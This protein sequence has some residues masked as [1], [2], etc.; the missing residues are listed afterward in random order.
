MLPAEAPPAPVVDAAPDWLADEP[1]VPMLE[2][3]FPPPALD[4]PVPRVEAAPD[5]EPL[6]AVEPPVP[7]VM[8]LVPP[9]AL[10][11][12]AP[13]VLLD[14]AKASAALPAR[15]V[16]ANAAV[17]SCSKTWFASS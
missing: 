8:L 11:P 12:P 4:P 13:T 2:L 16:A 10:E 17:R 9:P 6:P 3:L 15:N 14:C 1:P 7:N 5:P